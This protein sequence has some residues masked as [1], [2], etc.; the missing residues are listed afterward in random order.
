MLSTSSFIFQ[1]KIVS[2]D[3]S[4]RVL[5]KQKR[6]LTK[7]LFLNT[8]KMT[9]DRHFSF[10]F[11]E[12]HTL[13]SLTYGESVIKRHHHTVYYIDPFI[14]AVTHCIV[15]IT[16]IAIMHKMH[17]YVVYD[18]RYLVECHVEILHFIMTNSF[19]FRSVTF[20]CQTDYN[21]K[22]N[23]IHKLP[24]VKCTDTWLS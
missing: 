22:H 6:F 1:S 7:P 4:P 10:I 24:S 21:F 17:G 16:Y 18:H 3:N 8:S 23:P 15:H 5:K 12:C 13:Q 14:H 9:C 19:H 11:L 2:S 20:Y